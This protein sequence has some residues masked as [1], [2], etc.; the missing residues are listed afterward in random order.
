MVR[1]SATTLKGKALQLLALRDYSRAE[2]HQKLLSWLRVQAVKQAKGAG[3]QRPSACTS[4]PAGAEQRRTSA[5]AFKP[6]VEYSDALGTWEDARHLS[7]DDGPATDSAV[8]HEAATS[9]AHEQAAAWLEEQS[10]LIPA[11]LDEMQVKGWLDDRRAAEAL[12]HQRSARFGQ[13]RLRQALQQ[14]GIDA[15]TCRELLQ[16]TAQS[17]YA[18]AQALWQKK[19]GALPSTPAER[20]KQMRFLASRGFAA[21]IIQ[22]ILRHGP[23]DDGI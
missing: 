8:V 19:F 20:A 1:S 18:R 17:E 9:T 23:E 5:L 14:K 11:V 16:A 10:R 12:L 13:A 22:R 15:D 4:A 6:C 21:A 7:G 3:R 2:M